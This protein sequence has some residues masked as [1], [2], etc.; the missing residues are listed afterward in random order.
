MVRSVYFFRYY[1]KVKKRSNLGS[2]AKNLIA[3]HR[4]SLKSREI[5]WKAHQFRLCSLNAQS[6][7]NKAADFVCYATSSRADVF[8]V[9]ETWFSER[10]AAHRAQATPPGFI[11]LDHICDGR[12]GVG[13][14]LL[15]RDSLPAKKA[16]AG[17]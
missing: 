2:N 8:A 17:E 14:A 10:D 5:C 11:L 4:T 3:V 16:D 1:H 13:T 6:L 9:T 15:V 7:R 12:T